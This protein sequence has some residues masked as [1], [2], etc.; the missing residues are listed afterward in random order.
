MMKE[1]LGILALAAL[2]SAA[3]NAAPA[4][5]E[6][7]G[8]TYRQLHEQKNCDG[9]LSLVYTEGVAADAIATLKAQMCAAT[10]RVIDRIEYEPATPDMAQPIMSNGK[11]YA[12]T[13]VPVSKMRIA[14]VKSADVSQMSAMSYKIGQKDGV[15]FIVTS[16]VISGQ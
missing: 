1:L 7:L 14:F 8:A 5:Q 12:P 15:Y 9:L 13:L 4:S 2:L 3:V 6:Q 11:T 10:E 16:K